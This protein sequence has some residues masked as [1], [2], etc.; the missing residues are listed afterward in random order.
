MYNYIY[1]LMVLIKNSINILIKVKY[2]IIL[3]KN[4]NGYWHYG[5]QRKL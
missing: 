1:F 2:E 5:R 3:I 4:K